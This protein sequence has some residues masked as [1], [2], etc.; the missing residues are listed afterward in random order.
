MATRCGS[1]AWIGLWLAHTVT[2][3]RPQEP[4]TD[5][6]AVRTAVGSV[7]H[8]TF[9]ARLTIMQ[10]THRLHTRRRHALHV[11]TASWTFLARQTMAT[12]WCGSSAWVG[13]CLAHPVAKRRLQEPPTDGLAVR[14]TVGSEAHRTFAARLTIMQVTHRLHTRRRHALHVPTASWSFLAR[15]TMATR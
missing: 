13:L 5:G 10:V 7:A 14:T 9:A 4:P 3:R 15:Q 12:G 6:L 11:P 8:G 1:S 2:K